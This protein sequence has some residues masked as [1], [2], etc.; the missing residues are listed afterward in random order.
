VDE[1]IGAA[2][3]QSIEEKLKKMLAW[4]TRYLKTALLLF[5]AV[6]KYLK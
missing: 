5:E 3:K 6:F 4:C 1:L 2:P